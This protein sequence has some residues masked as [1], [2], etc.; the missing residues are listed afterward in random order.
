MITFKRIRAGHYYSSDSRF[1]ITKYMGIWACQ[2]HKFDE[3]TDF[4]TLAEAKANACA[5]VAL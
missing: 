3:I 4:N 2:D 5:S 1:T